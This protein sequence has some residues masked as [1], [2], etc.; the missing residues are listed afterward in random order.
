MR[1]VNGEIFVWFSTSVRGKGVCWPALS[2]ST[3]TLRQFCQQLET[4]I[5]NRN[6]GTCDMLNRLPLYGGGAFV[7]TIQDRA[8]ISTRRRNKKCESL[9]FI[10]FGSLEGIRKQK[11]LML[12]VASLDIFTSCYI[13]LSI[14][15][16]RVKSDAAIKRVWCTSFGTTST[17][18]LRNTRRYPIFQT[19]QSVCYFNSNMK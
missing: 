1:P 2:T 4:T 11:R 9:R 17:S 7:L 8:G 16:H 12:T 18:A 5:G 15:T 13:I 14:D 19:M 10:L 6:L 3:S